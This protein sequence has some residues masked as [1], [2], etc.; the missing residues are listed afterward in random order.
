MS[1]INK[2]LQ[3]LKFAMKTSLEWFFLALTSTTDSVTFR[4]N[5][6]SR[7][8]FTCE[9]VKL[10]EKRGGSQQ[11]NKI[12]QERTKRALNF[13]DE[14]SKQFASPGRTSSS[15]QNGLT[16]NLSYYCT[17]ELMFHK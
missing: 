16:M 12:D 1:G 2:N 4:L 9:A 7:I 14:Y 8:I 6:I 11:P 3:L 10:T 17:Y 13:I 5:S 15:D